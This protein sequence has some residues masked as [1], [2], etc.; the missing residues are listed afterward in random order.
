MSNQIFTSKEI[1]LLLRFMVLSVNT[2]TVTGVE[3][4]KKMAQGTGDGFLFPSQLIK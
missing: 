2:G 1:Y 3:I 4:C